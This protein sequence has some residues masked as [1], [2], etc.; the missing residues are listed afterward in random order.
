VRPEQRCHQQR[1]TVDHRRVDD[2]TLTGDGPLHQRR[3]DSEGQ[4]HAS[5]TEIADEIQRRSWGLARST[6]VRLGAGEGDVVDVVTGPGGERSLATPAGHPP[7]DQPL[8]R[9]EQLG[10]T[11]PES[12][13]DAGAKSLDEHV[14][15]TRERP[16][17]R[18]SLRVFQIDPG[19]LSTATHHVPRH[20]TGLHAGARAVGHRDRGRTVGGTLD[21][22]HVGAVIGEKHRAEGSRAQPADLDDSN[23]LQRSGHLRPPVFDP[24]N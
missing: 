19:R 16:D 1:S 3:A 14:G 22:Q 17:Q 5:A 7:V 15:V 6:D 10:R 23:P 11:D 8:I 2:L 13:G 18:R 4:E 24:E 20:E 9:R 21:S 12:L